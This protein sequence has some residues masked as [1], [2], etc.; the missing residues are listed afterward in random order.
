MVFEKSYPAVL[1]FWRQCE[2]VASAFFAAFFIYNVRR[3]SFFFT[4][5]AAPFTV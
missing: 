4:D 5:A 2:K 1:N 3:L